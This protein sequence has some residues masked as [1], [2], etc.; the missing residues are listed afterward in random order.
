MC[1]P[2]GYSGDLLN[3]ENL[4]AAKPARH[5]KISKVQNAM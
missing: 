5:I 2:N 4:N 3:L 1:V